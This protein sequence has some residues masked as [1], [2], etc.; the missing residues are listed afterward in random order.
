MPRWMWFAPFGIL[1]LIVGYTG[2]KLGIERANVTEG[3]V[4]EYY[5][6]E[7]LDDHAD[8]IGD[9][10]ALTDCVGV[11]GEMGQ[12]WIE[13]QCSPAGG[14]PAFLYGINRGGGLVYAARA[15]EEPEA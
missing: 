13:V 9:G 4:L 11:P 3:A 2:L 14:E 12:V 15:G 7:Y 8:L 6:T 10:A 1:V 5:A